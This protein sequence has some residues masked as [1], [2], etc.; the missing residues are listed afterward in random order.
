MKRRTRDTAPFTPLGLPHRH[1]PRCLPAPPQH[2]PTNCRAPAMLPP[3]LLR[4]L[5][6]RPA[7]AGMA[8]RPPA[9][10]P[11]L[12]RRR[13][14][15]ACASPLPPRSD[16]VPAFPWA[17]LPPPAIPPPL[18]GIKVLDLSRVLA[19]PY[20]TMLLA[21][22]GADVVKVE[23]PRGG[24][25][26]R[27]WGPPFALPQPEDLPPVPKGKEA[28]WASLPP[29]SAYFLAANRGKRSL[30]L[31]FKSPAGRAVIQR[32]VQ[33]ADVVVENYVPGKLDQLG[34]GYEQMKEWNPSIIFA[35]ISG[36][37]Q[38]GPYAQDAGYDV[39]VA[40]DAGLFHMYVS[41]ALQND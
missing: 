37:G 9:C 4:A 34:L 13:H 38:S 36:Y 19:G 23:N 3:T 28:Y 18:E 11:A 10:V 24:D 20:S 6:T 35:S 12:A 5:C 22:L 7:P 33:Q 1:R 25:D 40:A 14:Q 31:D 17:T 27:A 26:T 15:A 39:I 2:S 16:P 29:E 8:L 32:L 21:D 30:T 41:T